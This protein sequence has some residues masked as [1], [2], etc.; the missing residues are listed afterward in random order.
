MMNSYIHR[1]YS[2]FLNTNT[3]HLLRGVGGD[4]SGV[5]SVI[6]SLLKITIEGFT[7]LLIIIYIFLQDALVASIVSGVGIACVLFLVF[8]FKNKI[9]RLYIGI[10]NKNSL[11]VFEGIKE[12][13]VMHRE[14]HFTD[15]Y[16]KS[17]GIMQKA[18]VVH[19]VSSEVP[20]NIIEAS[21]IAALILALVIRMN[22]GV[23][24][25]EFIPKL[26]SF[27]V[28][29]FR[30]LPS[31]GRISSAFNSMVYAIPSMNACYENVLDADRNRGSEKYLIESGQHLTFE[32]EISVEHVSFRY[33]NTDK[34]VLSDIS[35]KIKKGSSVAL[36]GASGAGKTTLAD[37]ILGLLRPS[38]GK[39]L[40]DGHDI[41]QDP[42]SWASLIGFVPQSVYLIDDTIRNNVAFGIDQN[43][44]DDTKV[45]KA[46]EEAQLADFVHSLPNGLDNI[47]GDRGVRISGGQRQRIAIAR[48]MYED[49]EILVL[50]EAT[51]ALDSETEAAVMESINY[52]HG[53]KTL[54]IIAHRL[55]TIER[56]NYVYEVADGKLITRR[57]P[58]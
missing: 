21:C 32:K 17:F 3:S 11:Q 10:T 43:K 57:K 9:Y 28:A 52:L 37:I 8:F 48:A 5:H 29:A 55:T 20:A 13:M 1:G 49:P 12:I 36:I 42:S 39:V 54:I 40:S 26:G 15:E 58:V 25:T 44:I 27:A 38:D 41:H 22:Q 34:D 30:V 19:T 4:V 14:K 31:L 45:W 24:V 18:N 35:L 56:C 46:L 33:E 7:A 2:F 6:N 23:D 50:D 53:K 51:S 16:E 47:V